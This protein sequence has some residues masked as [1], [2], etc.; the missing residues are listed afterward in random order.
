KD[1]VANHIVD[2]YMSL[3][4]TT[5]YSSPVD[6]DIVEKAITRKL[7][8]SSVEAMCSEV[9]DEEIRKVMWSLPANKALGPDGSV[10]CWLRVFFSHACSYL[11]TVFALDCSGVFFGEVVFAADVFLCSP[12]LGACS[13]VGGVL[14]ACGPFVAAAC[15]CLVC[16]CGLFSV[17]GSGLEACGFV[18]CCLVFRPDDQGCCYIDTKGIKVCHLLLLCC[19]GLP[20][21]SCCFLELYHAFAA[22]IPA[23]VASAWVSCFPEIVVLCF[24]FA[25]GPI[26]ISPVV[27]RSISVFSMFSLLIT[28]SFFFGFPI[29]V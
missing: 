17:Q 11:L 29:A 5:S 16:F 22:A 4:G 27:A 28:G 10:C 7:S 8:Q 26:A 12:L 19:L 23:A 9:T 2:Y 1:E 15:I 20:N 25:S 6:D 13:L 21:C 18:C 3:L 14:L 24:G